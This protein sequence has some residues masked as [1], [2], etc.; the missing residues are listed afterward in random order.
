MAKF[1]KGQSGNPAGRKPGSKSHVSRE[2]AKIVSAGGGK[3]AKQIAQ[4]LVDMTL[5]GDTQAAR[6]LCERLEGKP[7]SSEELAKRAAGA[8]EVKLTPEQSRQK[9]VEILSQPEFHDVVE[10]LRVSASEKVQ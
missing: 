6:I 8:N 3:V 9:M 1:T 10:A 4:K 2:L 7:L 5:A